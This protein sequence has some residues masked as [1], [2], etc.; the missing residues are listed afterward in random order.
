MPFWKTLCYKKETWN[1]S[2]AAGAPVK[3]IPA[4]LKSHE[5][6]PGEAAE[7]TEL[8]FVPFQNKCINEQVL[9]SWIIW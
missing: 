9:F 8:R 2:T 5:K 3:K 1:V 4:S 7:H 6:P